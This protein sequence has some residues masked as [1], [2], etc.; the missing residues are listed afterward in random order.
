MK[1]I[2]SLMIIIAIVSADTFSQGCVAIRSTGGFCTAETSE[3]M[4][5]GG[6]WIFAANNRYFK[7]FRHFVGTDE[8]HE[9][10]EQKTEVINHSYSLDLTLTRV[11]NN[12]WSLA[13]TAPV[14]SN[15]RSSL[16][17]H[18]GNTG[19]KNAR[20]STHSFGLGDIR[21]SV[22][23]WL[24]DPVFSKKGNIQ[25]GLGIKLPTGDYKYEDYFIRNDSTRVLGPVDQSIQLGDGG[26][27]FTA[28]L[29][30]YYNLSRTF[31][32]YGNFYYLLNPREQ[33]GVSTARGGTPSA[34][35]IRYGSAVMSVPDQ[36]MARAGVNATFNRLTL[37]AGV[38]DEC[39]PAKDLIGGSSGFRR[40]GY[41]ISAEPGIT[42]QFKKATIYAF[43]PI[44]LIR[45]RTQSVPDKV[46]TQ[47]TGVYAQG[48]AAFADY[49]INIGFSFKF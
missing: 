40:P 15:A 19:G 36:Y 45:D 41:I 39:L 46:R 3:T 5:H 24:I 31:S 42:Y 16:Y 47:V 10:L 32:V 35:A 28:E 26:T 17:E 21:L 30:T 23:R 38:R 9:R 2:F 27:G 43:G 6:N 1:K 49:A 14:I 12:R 20:H 18:G 22:Y 11:I 44:A 48:D 34:T 8:Q 7:S 33:N 25:V 4:Q 29:N 13:L 37:S